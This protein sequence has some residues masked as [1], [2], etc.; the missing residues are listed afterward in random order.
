MGF[1]LLLADA[2]LYSYQFS[3]CSA[4]SNRSVTVNQRRKIPRYTTKKLSC[5][6]SHCRFLFNGFQPFW[7]VLSIVAIEIEG[8]F[9]TIYH[10]PPH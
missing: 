3:F 2:N 6:Y 4:S 1:K 8:Q 9:F 10:I 7:G 5:I